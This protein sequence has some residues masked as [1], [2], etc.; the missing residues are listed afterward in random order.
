MCNVMFRGV[1]FAPDPGEDSGQQPPIF[2]P[3]VSSQHTEM[4]TDADI[5]Q[6]GTA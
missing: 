4:E 5:R 6:V 2:V 1:P 3:A